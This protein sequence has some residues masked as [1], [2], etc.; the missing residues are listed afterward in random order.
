MNL[1]P[2]LSHVVPLLLLACDKDKRLK[3]TPDDTSP[4][5]DTGHAPDTELDCDT[6]FL[7]DDGECVPAAC[8]TG[9]WGNLEVDES[10]VY[11]DIAAGEGGDGSE[12][13]PFTSIQT[14]LDA[15]GDADGGMVAVAAGTYPETLELGREHDGVR[16]AGRCKELVV[17]DASVGDEWTPG[18]YV[19]AKSS[20]LEVSGV[21]VSGSRSV[22]VLV[23]S[24]TVGIHDSAVA[25]SVFTGVGAFQARS[26]ET[27]LTMEA[28][29][30]RGNTPLGVLAYDSGTSVTLRETTIEGTQP[31]ENGGRGY[32]IDVHGGASLDVEGCQ[33][34]ESTSIGMLVYDSGTSVSL[35]ETTVE[36]TRS[37]DNEEH[38]FGIVVSEGASLDAEGCEVRGSTV[39]GVAALGSGTSVTLR[40]TTIADTQP[41]GNGEGG[42]G[43]GVED[44]A[45]LSAEACEV[46]ANTRVGVV[47]I[48]TG[49]SVTLRETT[50]A[51][52]QPDAYG[53][54]GY[55]IQVHSGASLDAEASE[56]VGKTTVG[57]EAIDSGT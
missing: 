10:T 12:A 50:I 57:V 2:S 37:D 4:T 47:A 30:L 15:A 39:A 27:V 53:D 24:G 35:R 13:A 42:Y 43:I 8:G 23:G 31:D 29:A 51:D 40:E 25:D 44:G 26:Y 54:G 46:R 20:K 41:D 19:D 49:T 17:M 22:G 36:D 3:R 48:D 11:V 32:G 18:I 14:G 28:C 34:R 52:T 1:R 9:S 33:V 5:H 21:T 45:S 7:D 56:V 38:G 6:G 55:G 16:L